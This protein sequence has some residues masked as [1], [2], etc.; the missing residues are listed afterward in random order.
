MAYPR[1][2]RE[3]AREMRTK[4]KLSLIE[5]SERLALPKTTVYYWIRDLPLGRPRRENGHPGNVAMQRKY[6]LI[7]EEAY[8]QGEREFAE[9]ALRNPEFRDFVCL[10]IGEGYKRSRNT[11]SLANSDPGVIKL[12]NQWMCEF[13]R[14]PVG[15]C[16]QYHA[17]Q[18][19]DELAEFWACQLEVDPSAI[20]FQR[21]SN[22]S[23]LRNRTWRS[24]YGVLTVRTNDTAF[25][26]R[27]QGWIDSIK[28]QWLDSLASGRGATW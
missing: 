23:Q 12:A 28:R 22:S 25:R 24:K 26:A 13:S 6:R 4:E 16:V 2:L 5:I 3:R 20:A 7:R 21:K 11:V 18:N 9:L 10:Y 14:R 19:F 15:Y 1:Y 17:D 8:L 27:V